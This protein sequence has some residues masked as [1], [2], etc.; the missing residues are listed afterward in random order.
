[1]MV[2]VGKDE[3]HRSFR[4]VDLMRYGNESFIV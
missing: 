3:K 4:L 2:F 1:M